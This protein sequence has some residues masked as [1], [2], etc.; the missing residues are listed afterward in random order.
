MKTKLIILLII[1]IFIVSGCTRENNGYIECPKEKGE[2]C[3]QVYDPVCGEDGKT[4]SNS[5]VACNSVERYK[6]GEC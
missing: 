6:K 5:C 2:F 3:I 1:G 4:Y